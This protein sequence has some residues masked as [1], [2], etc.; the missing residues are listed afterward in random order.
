MDVQKDDLVKEGL[1]LLDDA[2]C[3]F[4]AIK[5]CNKSSVTSTIIYHLINLI[6][7]IYG[8]VKK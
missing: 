2:L 7:G 6:Y 1:Q 3:R 5:D 4:D 8:I